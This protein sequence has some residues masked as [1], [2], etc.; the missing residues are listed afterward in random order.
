MGY[1][2]QVIRKSVHGRSR[3]DED[4]GS[5][6]GVGSVALQGR[7]DLRLASFSFLATGNTQAPSHPMF[8]IR[9]DTRY[10]PIITAC[11]RRLSWNVVLLVGGQVARAQESRQ[12]DT[13]RSRSAF[14]AFRMLVRLR[15]L[16]TF[17]GRGHWFV[18][19]AV[20]PSHHS[21]M[22]ACLRLFV[23]H[24]IRPLP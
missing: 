22:L 9:K 2:R 17:W 4:V 6:E 18:L 24:S 10:W 5:R 1:C 15:L 14:R 16:D 21:C 3:H 20:N 7:R 8:K 12:P 11:R 23:G 13:H 19:V